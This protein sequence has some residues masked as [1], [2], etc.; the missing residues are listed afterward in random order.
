[1][2]SSRAGLR[3]LLAAGVLV[4]YVMSSLPVRADAIDGSWCHHDGRRLSILGPLIMTPAGSRVQG[5]YSRHAFAYVA[6]ANDP[7]PG[8]QIRMTLI[9]DELM[10]LNSGQASTETWRRCGPPVS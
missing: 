10:R 8:A 4:T 7:Q 5:D 2:M 6:P 1:M 3:F 9:N